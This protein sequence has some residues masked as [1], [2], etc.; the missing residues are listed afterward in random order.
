MT[1]ITSI[2]GWPVFQRLCKEHT[3]D[4]FG[5]Y[6]H[7]MASF[8]RDQANTFACNIEEPDAFE[9]ILKLTNPDVV[10]HAGGVCDLDLCEEQPDFAYQINVGGARNILRA[11]ENRYL[12]YMS[13]DLV[14]SGN[15]A[16]TG[17]KESDMPDPISIVGKTY[18]AAEH[19]I[20]KAPRHAIVRVALPIG[21]SL[22]GTKGAVDFI[23]KRLSKNKRMSLFHD[24]LRSL[25]HTKDLAEGMWRFIKTGAEGLFHF[26][27]IKKY[28]LY[29]IGNFLIER[30]KF[31]KEN[32]VGMLRHQEIGGPPRIG[33]V[34]LNSNKFYK[35]T[36]FY[37]APVFT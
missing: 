26:G 28:S 5:T 25:I 4:V 12:I 23:A 21:K 37:P 19:E 16:H 18:L 13:S 14:F 7:K 33:D 2:H 31:S 27:G 35:K 22:P 8:F 11:T 6:P 36:N 29:D 10:I 1:G 20:A 32:L 9:K 3:A 17:Y 30:Y 15:R 24:E 34:S